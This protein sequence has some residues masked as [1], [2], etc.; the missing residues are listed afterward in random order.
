MNLR[1][2]KVKQNLPAAD[3]M[4]FINKTITNM[5]YEYRNLPLSVETT[6]RIQ[7]DYQRFLTTCYEL[8]TTFSVTLNA[9]TRDEI[10]IKYT[11]RHNGMSCGLSLKIN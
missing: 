11:L 1:L 3:P 9:E 7:D 10:L 5:M 8:L 6:N 4:K 2:I